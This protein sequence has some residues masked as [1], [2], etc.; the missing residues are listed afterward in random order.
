MKNTIKLTAPLRLESGSFLSDVEIAYTQ[1]GEI[2]DH[3][4][5]VVL[6]CHTLSGGIDVLEQKEWWFIGRNQWIDPAKYC[7][8][9]FAA[10]GNWHGSSAP[11]KKS[12]KDD[13]RSDHYFP[14]VT[15]TDSVRA[16]LEALKLMEIAH[17]KI[18]IGGS[19]GGFCVYTWLTIAPQ[20]ID[21]AIIFQSA[22]RCSAHTIGLFSLM[23]ELITKDPCWNNGKYSPDEINSMHGLQQAIG[24]N[25][26]FA[27]SHHF[28]ENR[29]PSEEKRIILDQT[30]E[31]WESLSRID[32]FINQSATSLA[33]I[34]PNSL[35]CTIRASSLFDLERT[36]PDVWS[37]WK[38]MR[39]KLIQIPCNQDWRYPP[40]LMQEIQ[41]K[42][43][44]QNIESILITSN[45]KYGHGSYLYDRASIEPL[46]PF[47]NKMIEV[48]DLEA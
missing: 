14:T 7:I 21:T 24:L 18:A 47:L 10:L 22:S 5:N 19:F 4:D 20:L 44:C 32:S 34:D 12:S 11:C 17:I 28:F 6:V 8:I 15:V 35:L 2:N 41:E 16:H 43:R 1:Y 9:T 29:F 36:F 48:A 27:L 46:L 39:T 37:R 31:Y 40:E 38:M 25:R 26:L 33:G 30:T 23:R 13:L 3:R 45:S 42:C